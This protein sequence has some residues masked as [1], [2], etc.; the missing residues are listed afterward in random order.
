MPACVALCGSLCTNGEIGAES[1][2]EGTDSCERK[3]NFPSMHYSHPVPFFP[4]TPRCRKPQRNKQA[5][6][7]SAQFILF[8]SFFLPAAVSTAPKAVR[9]IAI[10]GGWSF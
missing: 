2:P 4:Q 5:A 6:S 9:F 10:C 1:A 7:A 3:L 8:I